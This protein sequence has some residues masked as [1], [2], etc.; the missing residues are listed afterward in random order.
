[1]ADSIASLPAMPS[2]SVPGTPFGLGNAGMNGGMRNGNSE[3]LADGMGG[4]GFSNPDLARAF[5]KPGNVSFNLGEQQPRVSHFL[6]WSF[7]IT[8]DFAAL[9][10]RSHLLQHVQR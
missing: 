7:R 1:M 2:K 3:N 9:R 4:R 6:R 10:C 8:A 5:G